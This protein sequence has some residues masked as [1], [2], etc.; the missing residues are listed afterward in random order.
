MFSNFTKKTCLLF[1]HKNFSIRVKTFF[2]GKI[3]FSITANFPP[4]LIFFK[5]FEFISET[6]HGF[7]NYNPNFVRFETS[8]YVNHLLGENC[9][10]LKNDIIFLTVRNVIFGL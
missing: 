5:K 2:S 10:I 7:F 9:Y 3:S 8:S 4:S 1:F 6:G